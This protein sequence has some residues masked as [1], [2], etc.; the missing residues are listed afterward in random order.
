L[1][2]ES[3]DSELYTLMRIIINLGG[4]AVSAGIIALIV[5]TIV[6]EID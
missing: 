1:A 5:A 2:G 6:V 4:L 3:E